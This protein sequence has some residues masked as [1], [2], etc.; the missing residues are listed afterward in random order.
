MITTID[1][2]LDLILAAERAAHDAADALEAAG[3]ND[4]ATALR[5][6]AEQCYGIGA[7]VGSVTP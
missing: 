4:D 1:T 5:L 7:A 3:H 6:L 2:I